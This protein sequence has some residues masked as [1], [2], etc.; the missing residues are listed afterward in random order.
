MIRDN[1]KTE[2]SVIEKILERLEERK[3]RYEDLASQ[4]NFNGD[5]EGERKYTVK[6]EMCEE[7]AEIV[8]EVAKDGGWIPCS[9]RLPKKSGKYIVTQKRY[10][11]DDR[12]HKRPIAVEVDYVEFNS[13]DGEWQRANFFEVIAWQPLPAP[14][15]KGE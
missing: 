9:E 7:L 15:Q 8:Q 14:Y 13:N 2:F 3:S 5:Y 12:T 6:V 10:A 11:I 1:Q 4:D